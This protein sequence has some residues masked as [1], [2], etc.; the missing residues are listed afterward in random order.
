MRFGGHESFAVREGWLSRGLELLIESPDLLVHEHAEDYLGVGRNMAKSIR[1]WLQAVGLAAGSGVGIDGIRA[2]E[3]GRLV[4][5]NDRHF[6]SV[7]TWWMLHVNLVT[8]PQDAYTWN[9]FFNHWG[10]PRFE[11]GT[12]TEALKR[13]AAARL[14][15]VP[16]QRTLERDIATLLQS[17]AKTIPHQPDDPEDS[18]DSPFQ[19][20]GL[21]TRFE[22]SG[23][24]QLNF[25]RKRVPAAVFGYALALAFPDEGRSD[26]SV[27][28]L[29]RG[30]NA[31]GRVFLLRGDD[32]YDLLTEYEEADPRRFSLRSQA[33]ERGIRIGRHQKPEQWAEHVYAETKERQHA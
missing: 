31:P 18:G 8:R 10:I 16:S 2:T 13:F 14:G 9:W 6:L 22:A 20:L 21:L 15:R 32:L 17:Y 26:F 28:E 1:H 25:G 29:E 23:A 4:L 30:E 11:R 5:K 12:C 33:G 19:N 7:D 24:Y 27:T 3:L